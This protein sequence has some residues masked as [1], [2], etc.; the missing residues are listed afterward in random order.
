MLRERELVELQ[1][2]RSYAR[3]SIGRSVPLWVFVPL[4]GLLLN[5]DD[6]MQIWS[7]WTA[8]RIYPALSTALRPAT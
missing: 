8:T 7:V 6:N 4:E 3:M 5:P 2:E 1:R